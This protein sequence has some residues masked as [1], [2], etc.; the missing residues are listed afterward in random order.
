M[1]TLAAYLLA[2]LLLQALR[3]AARDADGR[4]WAEVGVA[5]TLPLMVA[6]AGVWALV[7][8]VAEKATKTRQGRRP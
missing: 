5:L 6:L 3:M 7:V 1:T 2:A 4:W 8:W